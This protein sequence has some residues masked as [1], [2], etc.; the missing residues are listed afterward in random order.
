[1][2][3]LRKI[4]SRLL[5][6]S[7]AI[8]VSVDLYALE[9]G[10]DNFSINGFGTLSLMKGSD[11]ELG[12]REMLSQSGVFDE[13]DVGHNS[14]LGIQA[15]YYASSK[16]NFGAQFFVKKNNISLDKSTKWAY[17]AY[18][19]S[20][21][22]TVR[23]GRVGVDSYMM[24]DHKNVGFTH[25][26]THLPAEFYS[27]QTVD[28]LDGIDWAF[29]YPLFDGLLRT[30]LSYGHAKY[31]YHSNNTVNNNEINLANMF[32]AGISW[33]NGTW[34]LKLSYSQAKTEVKNDVIR[35]F[36]EA[37]IQA[38][39]LGWPE[40]NS[41]GQLSIDGTSTH[42]YSAAVAYDTSDW[43]IQSE[44]GVVDAN[45]II[46]SP[47][48]GYL[49]IGRKLGSVTPF[50]VGAWSHTRGGRLKM[51]TPALS[52]FNQLQ[53]DGQYVFNQF[54]TSQQTLSIGARWDIKPKVALK[55][56]WDKT[57]VDEY[58][59][60]LLDRTNGALAEKQ[61]LDMLSISVDF[62]F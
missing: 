44:L 12:F 4:H 3:L 18:K 9:T 42:Y 21:K 13:Y 22:N 11:S 47:I 36:D 20:P 27:S 60:L 28:S 25:L 52:L 34:S 15:D 61:K 8:L 58:G 26:W 38:A 17:L 16:L 56:Q 32:G 54:H 37:L 55:M 40:V 62:L 50:I 49:S 10:L 2:R 46:P 19:I 5:I 29:K 6:A 30:K 35:F 39:Q 53:Q 1:M 14:D 59:S 45:S 48:S 51:P 33:E 57:W 23:I 7:L 31:R 41:F 43:I 24:S